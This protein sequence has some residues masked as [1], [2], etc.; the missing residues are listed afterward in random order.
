MVAVPRDKAAE[1]LKKAQELDQ[2]EH[3]TLPLI[4]KFKSIT[5]AVAKYGRI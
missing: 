3:E 4:E 1:I 5:Q 2:I